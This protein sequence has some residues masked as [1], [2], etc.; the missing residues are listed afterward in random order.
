M[1][2]HPEYIPPLLA[3]DGWPALDT[4]IMD[5]VY[6][7]IGGLVKQLA[8][9]VMD[10][11]IRFDTNNP[12]QRKIFEQWRALNEAYAA[13]GVLAPS[14]GVHPFMAYL[15]LCRL[16]GKLA[17]F[18]KSAT[19]NEVLPHY[20]HDDLGHCFYT[21]KHYINDLLSLDFNQ[22]YEVRPFIGEGLRMKVAMEPTWMAP[23]CQMLVGVQS[24]LK[25]VQPFFLPLLFLLV[26]AFSWLAAGLCTQKQTLIMDHNS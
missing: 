26:V 23:A 10:Q 21:L 19:L 9:Q 14:T 16:V 17:V 20:D 24:N 15:E 3:C 4:D 1:K 12:E 6:N 22:G 25:P 11:N 13:F 5:Q 2:L 8:R 7:R 18:S